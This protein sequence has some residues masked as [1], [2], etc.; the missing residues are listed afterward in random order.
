[1]KV[2]LGTIEVNEHERRR[3]GART[4]RAI[5]TREQVRQFILDNGMLALDDLELAEEREEE[6]EERREVSG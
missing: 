1:M 4:G 5:A 6:R 3:I 2:A